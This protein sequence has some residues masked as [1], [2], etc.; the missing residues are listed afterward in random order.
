MGQSN[1]YSSLLLERDVS[2]R[3]PSDVSSIEHDIHA[4]N[5]QIRQC[6]NNRSKERDELPAWPRVSSF[7]LTF[8]H[9]TTY[10]H[11]PSRTSEA[12]W[13]LETHI[14]F[15]EA[16]R[17]VVLHTPDIDMDTVL[18]S[19]QPEPPD[20]QSI[21]D[22]SRTVL[23]D[24]IKIAVGSANVC[25][26]NAPR[27]TASRLTVRPLGPPVADAPTASAPPVRASP[28]NAPVV[29]TLTVNTPAV[30]T[31]TINT[32]GVNHPAVNTPA[33]HSP[34]INPLTNNPRPALYTSRSQLPDV[35]DYINK[36]T[37][38]A[39]RLTDDLAAW[40]VQEVEQFEDIAHLYTMVEKAVKVEDVIQME[41][42]VWLNSRSLF[43][44]LAQK[45]RIRAPGQVGMASIYAQETKT[46]LVFRR[47][48]TTW[49]MQW[50]C[51]AGSALD[52]ENQGHNHFNENV[53]DIVYQELLRVN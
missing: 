2:I 17:H 34:A 11:I 27:V 4:G 41:N 49:F 31:P 40:L 53:L 22:G 44:V 14:V 1:I 39:D 7:I 13:K 19:I 5:I 38:E 37:A 24:L 32:P 47:H 16:V 42:V 46:N 3:C 15:S 30:N 6:G 12:S 48:V 52:N 51:R 50:P 45:L 8:E 25:I 29:N 9:T 18:C 36:M 43:V 10:L 35:P 26:E 33:V 23:L 20:S 21:S 28:V